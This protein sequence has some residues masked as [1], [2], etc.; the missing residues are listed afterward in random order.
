MTFTSGEKIWFYSEKGPQKGYVEKINEK[1]VNV[2]V[3]D[4]SRKEGY[5]LWRVTEFFL[6]K[7][8]DEAKIKWDD[9][10]GRLKEYKKLLAQRRKLHDFHP[11]LQVLVNSLNGPAYTAT[12]YVV[13][14]ISLNVESDDGRLMKVDKAICEPIGPSKNFFWF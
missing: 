10:K 9:Y 1:T 3:D 5:Q 8:Q 4:T 12:V 13:N 2:L 6:G 7:S 14:R 11:G